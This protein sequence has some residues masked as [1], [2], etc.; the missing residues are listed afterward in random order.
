MLEIQIRLSPRGNTSE[1][2]LIG[3]LFIVNDGTGTEEF[4][5]YNYV[6]DGQRGRIEKHPRTLGAWS[7][8]H[9]I[10]KQET[11]S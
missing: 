9:A 11:P 4:G 1:Q 7:L 2:R 8:V 10:L 5:N 3:Q 6:L